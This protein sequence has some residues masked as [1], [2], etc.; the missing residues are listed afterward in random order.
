MKHSSEIKYVKLNVVCLKE[1]KYE[2]LIEFLR[3][4]NEVKG[5]NGYAIM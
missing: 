1:G 3:K 2:L 5:L 4:I